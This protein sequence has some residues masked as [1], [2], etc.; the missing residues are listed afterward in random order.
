MQRASRGLLITSSEGKAEI[1]LY[2]DSVA[3]PNDIGIAI[4][5]L[6]TAFPKMQALFFNLLAERIYDNSFTSKRLEDAVNHVLDNFQYKELNI[7]DIIKFDKKVKLHTYSSVCSMVTK[8]EA[9]FEDFEKRKID[10]R[11]FWVKKA[12][13]L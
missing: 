11:M 4:N 9:S 7:S 13:I 8:G 6:Q 10:E 12:D 2:N 5:K 3:N 1:S